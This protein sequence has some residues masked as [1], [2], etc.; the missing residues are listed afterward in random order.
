MEVKKATVK[1]KVEAVMFSIG[2]RIKIE[3][4]CKLCR[5]KS[6]DVILALQELKNPALSCRV[7]E[8][9]W[10]GFKASLPQPL[11]CKWCRSAV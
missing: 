5:A 8:W 4:I 3:D 9:L 10:R 7:L 1:S 6:E 11:P 2:K